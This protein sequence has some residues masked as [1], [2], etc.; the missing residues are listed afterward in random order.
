VELTR[1]Y[2]RG[3]REGLAISLVTLGAVLVAIAVT[4]LKA[5]SP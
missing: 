5:T 3:E 2:F 1:P 4:R